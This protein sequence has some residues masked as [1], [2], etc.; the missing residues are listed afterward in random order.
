MPKVSGANL[1]HV[2]PRL[3]IGFVAAI[4]LL[5]P[6][7]SK[8]AETTGDRTAIRFI[9]PETGGPARPRI[10]TDR[11]LAFFARIEAMNEQQTLN[12]EYPE[13]YVRVATDRLVARVMLASLMVQRGSE[14]PDL[15]KLA[16]DARAEL[17]DRVGG[18]NALEA[19]MK[20]EGIEE[21]ELAAFLRDQVRAAFYIDRGITPILTITED[22]LREAF[23]AA[24]HPYRNMK[25][26]DARVRLKRWVIAERQR[27]AEIEFLQGARAR[28]KIAVIDPG[29]SK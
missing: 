22:S 18:P 12:G 5:L 14:P 1:V 26:E 4:A 19:A 29:G 13:R 6:G 15:A 21:D 17:A 23:R 11:E 8:A 2:T 25:F 28:V 16:Q 7:A 24:I 10:I 9:A 20:K 27:S 3:R